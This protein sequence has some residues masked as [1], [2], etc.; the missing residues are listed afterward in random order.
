VIDSGDYG[1]P[2]QQ[3]LEFS[4]LTDIVE[5]SRDQH[6]NTELIDVVQ[7]FI[8]RQ[9]DAGHG[10]DGRA[11]MKVSPGRQPPYPPA[12]AVSATPLSLRKSP[13]PGQIR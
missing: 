13:L 1:A 4:D 10:S 2:G 12:V 8:R 11:Y 9:I 3:S 6:I 5:A 7:S